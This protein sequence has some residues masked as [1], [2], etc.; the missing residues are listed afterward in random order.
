LKLE[1][2]HAWAVA[3]DKT[4]LVVSKRQRNMLLKVFHPD[5]E[6]GVSAERMRMGG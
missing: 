2:K 6:A 4:A 3:R 1:K 5:N